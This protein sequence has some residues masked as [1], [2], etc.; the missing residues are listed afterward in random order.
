[1][2]IFKGTLKT[3][4]AYKGN[5]S[6]SRIYK[7]IY[8]VFEAFK[9]LIAEGVPPL[10][11]LNCAA[12]IMLG[13]RIY[14]NSR[15]GKLPAG[16]TQIEYIEA[17]GTQYIDTGFS[18]DGNTKV[19]YKVETTAGEYDA[20]PFIGARVGSTNTAR[21]FPIAY[22]NTD[23]ECRTAFGS[24]TGV[25]SN[26]VAGTVFTGSFN[27]SN[28]VSTINGTDYDISNASFQKT[29][30]Y[31]LYLFATPGYT[32]NL[33]LSHGK[34]YYC[35]IYDNGTLIRNYIPAKN[36]SN[37]VGLYDTINNTFNPSIGTGNFVGGVTAP[38]P[39]APIEI[40][41]VGD[42]TK[43]LWNSTL[44]VG[45]MKFAD[46]QYLNYPGYVCNTTPIPVEAGETYTISAN[47]YN[48]PDQTS[49][50]FVFYNNGSFVSSLITTSLT[51]TIPSG[52]NQLYYN[53]RKQSDPSSLDPSDI[54][55]VQLEKGSSPT[56]YEPYGYKIPVVASPINI[57]NPNGTDYG[58]LNIN[59][60]LAPSQGSSR[61]IEVEYGKTYT[62]WSYRSDGNFY[63]CVAL[64][65]ENMNMI[66]G[67]RT[68]NS[69]NY[70]T[71][72][73][74]I[75][76][77]N[78]SAKYLLCAYY[79]GGST[80]APEKNMIV[81]GDTV[82]SYEPYF[83]PTTTNIFLD[84]PLRKIGSGTPQALPSGY[85][86]VEYI[87]STGTQYINTGFTPNQDT[88]VEIDFIMDDYTGKAIYGARVAA[89]NSTF[90]AMLQGQNNNSSFQYN[91]SALTN[92]VAYINGQSYKVV[93]DKNKLYVDG[94]LEHT[95]T[96]ANFTCPGPLYLFSVN[97]SG[98]TPFFGKISV[99]S[100]KIWD[101][102]TLVRNFIPCKNSSNVIGMYDTV[103]GTFFQN[104]G[105]GT[106]TA[107]SEVYADY[108][109]F[110]SQ[111]VY[112]KVGNIELVKAPVSSSTVRT[113]TVRT[114]LSLKV[115]GGKKPNNTLTS[116]ILC[117]HGNGT[118]DYYYSHDE[119]GICELKNAT[120]PSIIVS[121]SR[122]KATTERELLD[123]LAA[124]SVYLDFILNTPTEE[125]ITI[126]DILL[127]NGTNIIS[128]GTSLEPSNMW[129]K[130]KGK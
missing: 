4:A 50:G 6:L 29:N 1:M 84:E 71:K 2:P 95:F 68:V 31:N 128:V 55:N 109:D 56:T 127:N 22:N 108:I 21:F 110:E 88:K 70:A 69:S 74:T 47:N 60:T 42:K 104:A 129:I 37:V 58:W 54:T 14:G 45:C 52:V 40:E 30:N 65:D 48:D 7:G 89:D 46:G 112:R 87:K 9:T 10:T 111:K 8:L 107:G 97:Q 103:S 101:N 124:N 18:P 20:S 28:G 62:Y 114:L 51:V 15:Q 121:L 100:F 82:S 33:Y 27:P 105:T 102:G 123:W 117:T 24:K 99:K 113:N 44:R 23:G 96:Y 16:Y 83:S 118:P 94:T 49:S 41:S 122:T 66:S 13:Y 59:G 3:G 12:E 26:V 35:K 75:T 91:T 17:T 57:W 63:N 73:Q 116:E 98:T 120:N 81:E 67:T 53:F 76:I 25:I 43:N 38:T 130:Y 11:L 5:T 36:S 80:F 119:E 39:N 61:R 86:Q 125:T 85:T 32:D 72:M 92:T 126:P 19:D 93:Q 78:S 34:M 106:F 90:S 77:N 64:L 79:T 115:T